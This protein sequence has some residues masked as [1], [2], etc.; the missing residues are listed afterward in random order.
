MFREKIENLIKQTLKKKL[1]IKDFK[2]LELELATPP[3]FKMGDYS[4]PCFSL[5]KIV[6]KSPREIAEILAEGIKPTK[7]IEKVEAVIGYLNFFVN[8][9]LLAEITIK[10]TLKKK[11]NYGKGNLAKT[12]KDKKIILEFSSP[13]TNKPQHLGHLRNNVL[14]E[15]LASIL[16]SQNFKIIKTNLINDRG[17]HICKSMLAY[18][19]FGNKETPK[20]SGLKGDYLV[21]KYY[22]LFGEK[23]KENQKLLEEAQEL[24][25]KWEA[26][27]KET[28]KLWQKMNSWVYQGFKKTYKKLG[29]T[30]DRYDFESKVYES[31]KI[32]VLKAFKKGICYKREDGAIEIDLNKYNLDKKVLIRA[33]GTTIYIIPDIGVAKLRYKKEKFDQCLYIT[34]FEQE[35]HFK[36][37]FKILELFNPDFNWHDKLFHFPYGM[38]F[39]P[40]GKIKSREGKT[41]EA[42]ELIKEIEDLAKKEILKREPKLPQNELKKR[43]EK[44]ALS[45]L[46]FFLLKFTPKQEIHFD[47]QK[48]VSFEGAT[49]PYL[50]YT[51][52]RIKSILRKAGPDKLKT[53]LNFASFKTEEEKELIKLIYTFADILS[54]AAINYNPAMLCEYLLQLAS[55]FNKFY[56]KIPVL[57]AETKELKEA[58]VALIKCAAIVIK[59]G[60]KILGIETLE[61]M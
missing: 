38:V 15:A 21:G 30:F 14:G 11:D 35:Y 48:E 28:R 53:K 56:Q 22:V 42:D 54:L 16:K 18:Q 61:K 25:R 8:K 3:D 60:L 4:W 1:N 20:S 23:V 33:D 41:V 24:L 7:E 51:Y 2:N 13:N 37:L 29:V 59:N 55:L 34:G 39:L 46:K 44:I 43:A 45:S 19:K 50:Q 49:G 5:A 10:K 17:I 27:D 6:K 36:V 26:G 40:E 12:S 47:P 32:E 52:A 9:I 58:R 31:G 57:K